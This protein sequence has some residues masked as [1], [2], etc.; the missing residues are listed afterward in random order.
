MNEMP[1]I[2]TCD[3][4]VHIHEC[5]GHHIPAKHADDDTVDE[6]QLGFWTREIS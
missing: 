2:L 5:I 1:L 6:T 3:I 4:I